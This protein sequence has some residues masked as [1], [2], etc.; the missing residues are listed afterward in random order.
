[1]AAYRGYLITKSI[2]DES[3]IVT[4][5]GHTICRPNSEAEAKRQLDEMLNYKEK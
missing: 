4:K 2:F 1:M 5:D 3:V